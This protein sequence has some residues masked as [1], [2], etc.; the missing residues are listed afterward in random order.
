MY[1]L[2]L[3][4]QFVG[5]KAFGVVHRSVSSRARVG[6]GQ[7]C[8]ARS[9]NL[10]VAPS[11][12]VRKLPGS[13]ALRDMHSVKRAKEADKEKSWDWCSAV[14]VVP[15]TVLKIVFKREI[16]RVDI[17]W[18]T[19]S[20]ERSKETSVE[21]TSLKLLQLETS[22]RETCQVDALGLLACNFRCFGGRLAV[23]QKKWF[24]LV[25]PESALEPKCLRMWS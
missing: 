24:L 21:L 15:A 17:F 7:G 2:A 5:P 25:Q 14:H 18:T 1:S 8:W 6:L 13:I 12:R 16:C 9:P 10:L 19:A 22:K 3:Y 4:K 23:T 11:H 20:W